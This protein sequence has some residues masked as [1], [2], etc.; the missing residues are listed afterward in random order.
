[1]A[2]DYKKA[3]AAGY[4]DA[5]IAD[6]LASEVGF[7]TKKAREAGY[8]DA[9]LAS[10]L[11]GQ[12]S[13]KDDNSF[14]SK[15]GDAVGAVADTVKGGLTSIYS[16]VSDLNL[17]PAAA[18]Q[19]KQIR[20]VATPEPAVTDTP[21]QTP[22]FEQPATAAPVVQKE[23]QPSTATK[24][25]QKALRGVS[26]VMGEISSAT[27]LDV[28]FQ[29]DVS[30]ELR[31]MD[32]E[33]AANK[34]A[35]RNL[36][37][38]DEL[39]QMDPAKKL[40]SKSAKAPK[41]EAPFVESDF[42]KNNPITSALIASVPTTASGLIKG[43]LINVNEIANSEKVLSNLLS[44]PG[45]AQV[46]TDADGNVSSNY[47]P[48]ALAPLIDPNNNEVNKYLDESAQYFTSRI[49]RETAADA[50]NNGELGTWAAVVTAQQ[51]PQLAMLVGSALT[52]NPALADTAL[53]MMGVSS[54]GNSY[55]E[56]IKSGVPQTE[57][58]LISTAN[59]LIEKYT[60]KMGFDF[61]GDAAGRA[62]SKAFGQQ[63]LSALATGA[64]KS[65]GIGGATEFGEEF[66]GSIGQDIVANR[67]ANIGLMTQPD[68]QALQNIADKSFSDSLDE[69]INQGF[70]GMA[71]GGLIG[72]GFAY[73]SA[74]AEAEALNPQNPVLSRLAG[75]IAANVHQQL[76]D[77]NLQAV[78]DVAL[79]HNMDGAAAE[80]ISAVD[81][82]MFR[83]QNMGTMERAEAEAT[84][85]QN[86]I[87]QALSGATQAAQPAGTMTEATAAAPTVEPAPVAT[88]PA[89][90][91]E[92]VFYPAADITPEQLP[93]L[94]PEQRTA[95]AT[96]ASPR[97]V[98]ATLK[99]L[100]TQQARIEAVESLQISDAAKAKLHKDL[101]NDKVEAATFQDIDAADRRLLE[102]LN[103]QQATAEVESPN[104]QTNI[105][106]LR[107]LD[108]AADYAGYIQALDG[109]LAS[110]E[111]RTQELTGQT[112]FRVQ[113]VSA[114][115]A[116]AVTPLI[117]AVRETFGST[118]VPF[119]ATEKDAPDG[120]ALSGKAH[121]NVAN[122]DKAVAFVV[123][124]EFGHTMES[125]QD[126]A[127]QQTAQWLRENLIPM[128]SEQGQRDYAERFLTRGMGPNGTNL[129]LEQ[130]N[131]DP[132]LR[133]MLESEM[134]QDFLGKRMTDR[135]FLNTLAKRDPSGFVDFVQKW[136]AA[137]DKMIKSLK[138]KKSL[139]VQDIDKYIK[140]LD[141]AK[142]LASTAL[143]QWRANAKAR[144]A[145][146]ANPVNEYGVVGEIQFAKKDSSLPKGKN[147]VELENRTGVIVGARPGEFD[148]TFSS[149]KVPPPI[150]HPVQFAPR[151]EQLGDGLKAIVES[152]G[153]AKLFEDLFG[154]KKL[155][156][157]P[158]LG[159]YKGKAEPSMSLYADGITFEQADGLS[160][161]LGFAFAQESTIVTQ[162]VYAGERDTWPAIYTGNGTKLTAEQVSAARA[163]AAELGLDY[164]TSVDGKY[165][166]FFFDGSDLDG[167]YSRVKEVQNAAG[168]KEFN[169]VETRSTFNESENYTQANLAA[170]AGRDGQ[171]VRGSASWAGS[172]DL[173]RRTV[174]QLVIPYARLVA[175]EGYRL[176]PERYGERFGLNAE[177]V[178][179]IS[180]QLRPKSG[181]GLST[182]PILAGTEEL[183]VAKSGRGGKSSV[184]DVLWALQN[185]AGKVGQISIYDR[186]V[187]AQRVLAE[188][189][190]DEV[191]FHIK[192]F[193]GKTAI[194]WYDTALTAA[195]KQ[196]HSVFPELET[197]VNAE[198]MFDA[199]LGIAS[200]G[201]DVHTNSINGSRVYSMYR[202]GKAIPEIVQQLKGS[203]GKETRAIEAN[204]LKLHDL[205]DRN[206]FDT[207][208]SLFNEKKTVGE[209]NATLR[210]DPRLKWA[211]LQVAGAAEQ[212][213]NGWMVF[214][215]KIGSFINNLHGDYSTLTADLWFSRTWNRML[216]FTFLHTP[217]QE[218]DKYVAFKDALVAEAT[219]TTEP[220]RVTSTG[221]ASY[222]NHGNDV[223]EADVAKIINDPDAML[224]KAYELEEAFRKSGYKVKSDLRRA[225]KNWIEFRGDTVAAPRNDTE[226]FMQQQTVE[227]AARMIRA[228]T[229]DNI[230]IADIQA[231][232]WFHE[233]ELF[234]KF[235]AASERAKPA[236]YAD[237]AKATVAM[238][239]SGTLYGSRQGNRNG[240]EAENTAA[241][242]RK[243]EAGE[244]SGANGQRRD[245]GP[246][247]DAQSQRGLAV[248][249]TG[250]HYS[251]QQR[252]RLDGRY[253]GTGLKGAEGD[254]LSRAKDSRLKTRLYFYVDEGKGVRPEAGVG[255]FSHDVDLSNLYDTS[256]RTLTWEKDPYGDNAVTANNFET[257]VLNAGYSGYYRPGAFGDQG[258]A[259][260]LG[261]AAV[262]VQPKDTP[263]FSR[264][265]FTDVSQL[266][267][268]NEIAKNKKGWG[269][270]LG[271]AQIKI[272]DQEKDPGFKAKN[273]SQRLNAAYLAAAQQKDTFDIYLKAVAEKLDLVDKVPGLKGRKRTVEKLIADYNSDVDKLKDMLRGTIETESLAQAR[274]LYEALRKAVPLA[275]VA[276]NDK[277]SLDPNKPPAS[278]A[279]YRDAKLII[280]VNGV[281]AELIIAPAAL[282]RAKDLAH[283]LYE[284]QRSLMAEEETASPSRSLK[285]RQ[286][287]IALNE[288]MFE[289]YAPAVERSQSSSASLRV[290]GTELSR[291]LGVLSGLLSGSNANLRLYDKSVPS[292]GSA[293]G[294]PS[295]LKN[296]VPSGKSESGVLRSDIVGTSES[297]SI[298]QGKE[299]RFS[300]KDL[301]PKGFED[302]KKSLDRV[303]KAYVP[304]A[305]AVSDKSAI[306]GYVLVSE[307]PAAF[308]TF[309]S[310]LRL[311]EGLVGTGSTVYLKGSNQHD[312]SQHNAA[313]PDSVLDNL[314]ALLA[315][316]IAIYDKGAFDRANPKSNSNED[317][318]LVVLPVKVAGEYVTVA[319]APN[320]KIMGKVV[321]N[322]I[323]SVHTRA[324]KTLNLYTKHM[325]YDGITGRNEKAPDTSPVTMSGDAG[326]KARNESELGN[327]IQDS[328]AKN[329]RGEAPSSS[330]PYRDRELRGSQTSVAVT[331]AAG[332]DLNI[333]QAKGVDKPRSREDVIAL[334]RKPGNNPPP[335]EERGDAAARVAQD[336]FNRFRVLQDWLKENGVSLSED[337]DVY[338][339]ET[340]MS[341]RIA[342]R[343]EDFRN[344]VMGPL[345]KKTQKAGIS[346]NDIA[347]FLKMQHAQEA[348]KRARE[349]QQKPDAT[350]YGVSDKEAKSALAAFRQRP[351]FAQLQAI[352]SEWRE[353]TR[354]TK[355]ILV[356]GGI[357]SPEMAKAWDD[358]YSFYVPVKGTDD[359]AAAKTGTGK[360][361]NVN[362]RT[363]M[364]LGHE[365]RDEAIIENI[366]RDHERAISLDE[367]NRVGKALI[368][369]ALEAQNDDIV[370]VGKP[371]LRKVLKQGDTAYMVT[372]HG[373]D[374]A[375]FDSYK[376][377][378]AYIS[379]A[380]LKA[381]NPSSGTKMG[382]AIEKTNDNVRVMLQAS[383]MLADNEVNVYVGGRAVRV[384][385]NDEIAARAYTNM[386]VEQLNSI[387]SAS[388]E[389]NNWLSKVY[390]GY[391]P[392]FI[393]TNPIRDAI[394]GAIT[395]AGERGGLTAAKIF[396]NY[397]L[398]IKEL[399]KFYA[400]GKSQLVREYRANGGSTGGAYLSDLERIGDDI[401]SAYEEYSGSLKTYK[402]AYEKAINDG[403]SKKAAHTIAALRAGAAGFKKIP[404]IGHFVRLMETLNAV[405]ENALRVA[406]YHTLV[407]NGETKG[408]AAAQAK[409]LMNFNRK[410][411]I[412]N[413]AGALYLFY[414]PSV[415]GSTLIK[416]ALMDS[417]YRNQAR[418]LAGSM[419]LAAIAVAAL[420]MA[421]DDEDKKKWEQTP[422]HIKDGNIVITT[423]NKQIMI[424]L[425]YGYRV[426]WTLGN[427][428]NDAAM[429]KDLDKLSIRMASSVLANF[430]PFGNPLEGENGVFQLLPTSMKMALGPQMNEDS[431]GRPI[432]PK[433]YVETEP[434]SQ[435]MNRATN[436]SLYAGVAEKLNALTGGS[437]YEKGMV[438][439]S[440]EVLRFWVKSL[441][442]GTGQFVMDSINIGSA[443][444]QGVAPEAARD[445][446]VV[447]RFVR[448]IG[449]ADARAAYWERANKV[450]EAAGQVGQARKAKD[451]EGFGDLVDRKGELAAMAK[452]SEG[453]L[454]LANSKRDAYDAIRMDDT[455][456]L[457]E[458][459]DMMREIEA[460]EKAVYD[461]YIAEFDAVTKKK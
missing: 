315:D 375:V 146:S 27:G 273:A 14:T 425:P 367:K 407:Q 431:F 391:S 355:D 301:Q 409:N 416:R 241:F 160:K 415:Q 37:T 31:R 28:P 254:R 107:D 36:K 380:V 223:T 460:E 140:E 215:P 126:P 124:H 73:S 443:A 277:S 271:S 16:K 64:A 228:R 134:V 438:D 332:T 10:H 93:A 436:G 349:I 346:I 161:L 440:P 182:A 187:E 339:A 285:L 280:D 119:S 186:S 99:G 399:T 139:G 165:F 238:I 155:K 376:D 402:M 138:G 35:F 47:K 441:T 446:P 259:I 177:Q 154:L 266:V 150:A 173:F 58:N 121:V 123:A 236:D 420:N 11:V 340:L 335:A 120:F 196:Y 204:L 356:K 366:L 216:G 400:T 23:Y 130:V 310:P 252:Q 1:M 319:V 164:S 153:A 322:F 292:G 193:A 176:D 32:S 359:D 239:R 419:A 235:G 178:A 394:Q 44:V 255:R 181:R 290:H 59:G 172:P 185:R 234:A 432:A 174:D 129:T 67:V 226:R 305:Y 212:T 26:N 298:P 105:T 51:F 157:Y 221:K 350:A 421:G 145:A 385:I 197:D 321:V 133:N 8:S 116:Q 144:Q 297:N 152:K 45:G 43:T 57:A 90:A 383:P 267:M 184:T 264:K 428:I 192:H 386:G 287:I 42:A 137:L 52:R 109:T 286:R 429:G 362:G 442:G 224:A 227:R 113:P 80:V 457:K 296:L 370:T 214:G 68:N 220:K 393:L 261:D 458:K 328:A 6:H 246:A 260:L 191:V 282:L 209:W 368:K 388:R 444:V 86:P 25:K 213:V 69:A 330:V 159:S 103:A 283:E 293:T 329:N 19:E 82:E 338:L 203:F 217:A 454:K 100:P 188:A 108:P 222:W 263:A 303:R 15:V 54:A 244:T 127:D 156:V 237:A 422:D 24:L 374:I 112:P 125:S 353:I 97:S 410:G 336:K 232:L 118:V 424:T 279:G 205:V 451:P 94:D 327:T 18:A 62:M 360:G 423:G 262:G 325:M 158:T 78:R 96:T 240:Q 449:V 382:Y 175:S 268:I 347:D 302:Y 56:L 365:L 75:G 74:K 70:A 401:R 117:E 231:A 256:T 98:I 331:P 341:G 149:G 46:T 314:P 398:A 199:I 291:E 395:L 72:A 455:L 364:R 111:A 189:I 313:I 171:E 344:E 369:F 316:P 358:T 299:V 12:F 230:T 76:D 357:L 167:F 317:V 13:I 95:W 29:E 418:A 448:D 308:K 17:D 168:F 363:K 49:S 258:V 66:S 413:A 323:K 71:G 4:S 312:N 211:S 459:R 87:N 434:D 439:V 38:Q 2:F 304:G 405:T 5:E 210:T 456:T 278:E 201:A 41:Q 352:A 3:R 320:T 417:P 208:R 163:K 142:N 91:T 430:S 190:A 311:G 379:Q 50:L 426:F 445:I 257:A 433:K 250:R 243:N 348:N 40:V 242:S 85:A 136:I 397:P 115:E 427:V 269:R 219:K 306:S 22:A 106:P 377:A 371:Q 396:A 128:I 33:I 447:R 342:T 169:R 195:K 60:E 141:R 233:K 202:E 170:D 294:M 183:D 162:P 9:E 180:E 30:N 48:E 361:L 198:M 166:K 414:N 373:S 79:R 389:V 55:G 39:V 249:V 435:N 384:Q 275:D 453:M 101:G 272:V 20:S 253:Y 148:W 390:T 21:A 403:K 270:H 200:Q 251:T 143:I 452:F 437:K 411:E 84:W 245:S 34:E 83:R 92:N 354:K 88:D 337:A 288:K 284:E 114:E 265:A 65:V 276:G 225:A 333:R 151:I 104:E 63:Y 7:D 324:P 229:G 77:A 61:I 404:V 318:Y 194:G 345:V 53:N 132:E 387:L 206:G 179:Y 300:R 343:K 381:G 372:Y 326:A 450:K 307:T 309:K 131:A 89:L 408:R 122:L 81:A 207:M 102:E 334:S 392:D 147:T 274:E 281:P 248:N 135:K 378:Q 461:E 110:T 412:A 247:S 289:I 218:A 295:K 406:T 351:D